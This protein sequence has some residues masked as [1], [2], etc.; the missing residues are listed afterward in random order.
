MIP[1][2]SFPS[3]FA[4]ITDDDDDDDDDGDDADDNEDH[5]IADTDTIDDYIRLVKAIFL[6]L[7]LVDCDGRT[8]GPTP[9]IQRCEEASKK[10]SQSG[11]LSR[12]GHALGWAEQNY[13]A[14][15]NT[16]TG[17]SSDQ[18]NRTSLFSFVLQFEFNLWK[19]LDCLS[20][21]VRLYF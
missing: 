5:D 1:Q 2:L 12:P 13:K 19:K 10:A 9:T 15:K 4:F 6:M 20:L 18:L 16:F 3:F 7:L 21:F 11:I 17:S 14:D 8:D